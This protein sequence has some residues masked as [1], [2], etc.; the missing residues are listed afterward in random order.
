MDE[1]TR[2]DFLKLI[3]AAGLG[4]SFASLLYSCSQPQSSLISYSA[5]RRPNVVFILT[6]DQGSLDVNCYGAK[7]LYTPHMDRLAR[8]GV[9]FTQ[10]YVG[11]PIC[12]PSRACL[13][14]GR[15]PQHAGLTFNA[16]SGKG[17]P[18]QET[19][20][21]EV[22]N[23][24][25]YRTAC[26]GKWHLGEEP[27]ARPN[28]QGF[29]EFFGHLHGCIDNYSHF[30]SWRTP[31]RH[32][33]WE[34]DKEVWSEGSFFPDLVADRACRFIQQNRRHPFF[35]Y[36]A[37]NMPHYPLQPRAKFRRMYAHLD[38]PRRSYAAFLSN[39]DEKIGQ[40]VDTIDRLGLR[41]DTLI[42]FLS[43]NGHSTEARNNYGGGSAGPYRGFKFSLWEGG[44][45]LPCI[46]SW[47]GRVPQNEVRDQLAC[48]ADW[49][50][51]IAAYCSA[52]LPSVSLDGGDIRSII[53]SS[54]ATSP[55]RIL[56][57]QLLEQWAVRDGD[58]KLVVN[59]PLDPRSPG[60]LSDLVFLANLA[61]DVSETHNFAQEHPEIVDRLTKLHQDWLRLNN[62]YTP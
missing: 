24:L 60:K 56:H 53:D 37:F 40:V 21:A 1:Q 26:I 62:N 11:A 12:S 50:P 41:N 32:D 19:T 59:P 7:D 57:W 2:R 9:R 30:A 46:V 44:I 61:Q 28:D 10:F 48:S 13:L 8:Q 52:S 31:L 55:H 42:V 3:G 5:R 38:E 6:D 29:D 15:T 33:L 16:K 35:L 49:L 45:R 23:P 22:L 47:P 51:T 4:G 27:G 39:L 17:L 25:D 58:W 36:L 20:I 34:N 54:G 18:S 43:D 14:T